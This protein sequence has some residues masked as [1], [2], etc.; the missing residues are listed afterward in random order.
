MT[1]SDVVETI[2]ALEKELAVFN[3]APSDPIPAELAAY[4]ETQNVRITAHRTPSGSPAVAVLSDADGVLDVVG[5][6]L[7]REFVERPP[8]R[9]G[10]VGVSDGAYRAILG[11]LKET[12]FTS[13]DAERMLYA[14]REIE[15]RAR[16]TG[17]GTI[18]AGFQWCSVIDDQRTIYTDLDRRGI[19]V[20]VYGVPDITPPDL[21]GAQVHAVEAAEIAAT[22]FVAFD[23]GGDDTRKCA[24]LAEERAED[25]FY[26]VWTYDAGLVDTVVDYLGRTYR[27]DGV[28]RRTG[29]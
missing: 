1:L 5:V 23:G 18:H 21:G 10:E 7:L 8:S 3:L 27:T 24:L 13:Y 2:R 14:S 16:R 17:D 12:T 19:D 25:T 20:H 9:P 29:T 6:D 4:F 15:D 26:G 11:H 22:W 28:H